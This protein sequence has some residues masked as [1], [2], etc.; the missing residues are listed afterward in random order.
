ML[1]DTP[2]GLEAGRRAG[3]QI[4]ALTT[5]FSGDLLPAATYI[6]DFRNLRASV[7]DGHINLQLD[8]HD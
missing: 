1:E 7:Q 8:K 3:A 5:T 6:P 4:L 2:A